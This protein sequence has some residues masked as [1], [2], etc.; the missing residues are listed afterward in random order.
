[1]DIFTDKDGVGF[2]PDIHNL[3]ADGTPEKT[4]TGKWR[5]V[6]GVNT[7]EAIAKYFNLCEEMPNEES[8]VDAKAAM[9]D[10]VKPKPEKIDTSDVVNFVAVGNRIGAEVIVENETTVTFR[11]GDIAACCNP[12]AFKT[13]TELQRK[14]SQFGIY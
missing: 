3:L 5:K 7:P 1:M 2:N 13:D 10:P 11:K 8:Y 9:A 6:R 14:L 12:K 4:S